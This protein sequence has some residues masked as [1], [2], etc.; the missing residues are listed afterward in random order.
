MF[1]LQYVAILDF[2][3]VGETHVSGPKDMNVEHNRQNLD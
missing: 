2:C 3:A 1:F